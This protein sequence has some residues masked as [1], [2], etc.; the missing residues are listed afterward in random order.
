M[1][2]LLHDQAAGGG[3]ALPGGAKA[4]PHGAVDCQVD[5]GVFQ[6]NDGVLAAHLQRA[7]LEGA[8][9]GLADN[10]SNL[11][12]PGERNCAQI[13]VR[14]QRCAGF[15]TEAG[16]NVDHA[17]GQSS[18]NQR[19]YKIKGGKWCVFRRFDH[20]SVAADQRWKKLP[21]GNRHG[22]VPWGNHA[23]GAHRHAH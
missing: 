1:H 13:I 15:F 18:V 21:R 3:A 9:R 12:R 11:A 4:S 10:A 19:G 7:V 6:N 16:H 2:A 17:L 23:A 22:K 8:C 14:H 20:A 5:V